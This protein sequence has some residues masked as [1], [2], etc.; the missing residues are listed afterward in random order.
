MDTKHQ[1]EYYR[2]RAREYDRI[3]Q[4]PE[5]Q[6]DLHELHGYLRSSFSQKSIL[7]IAC[8]TGYWTQTLAQK[9]RAIYAT[10][11]NESMLE[12]AKA[13]NYTKAKM[14]FQCI[15]YRD[16]SAPTSPYEGL[17]SGFYGR[18]SQKG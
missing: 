7:E 15:D 13:R 18:T 6:S 9:A 1:I 2:Q 4:K 16:L 10:D 14:Q 8:G 5:R 3:Y 11:I 12:L 17:F